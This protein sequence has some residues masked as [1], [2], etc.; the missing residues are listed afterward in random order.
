MR[1]ELRRPPLPNPR[2][3]RQM[4]RSDFCGVD[5]SLGFSAP[6]STFSAKKHFFF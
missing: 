2:Q 6:L 4:E 1:H 5:Y 3:G